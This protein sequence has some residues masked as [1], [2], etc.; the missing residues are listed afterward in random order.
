MHFRFSPVQKFMNL[1]QAFTAK[2]RFDKNL[3]LNYLTM[4]RLYFQHP[5]YKKKTWRL[6]KLNLPAKLLLSLLQCGTLAR[7]PRDLPSV[8]AVRQCNSLSYS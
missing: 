1:W 3:H 5:Q 6:A 2:V 7:Q 8:L 4:A